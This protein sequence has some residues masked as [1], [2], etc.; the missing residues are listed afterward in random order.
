MAASEEQQWCAD[1]CKVVVAQL[2]EGDF[3]D[4]LGHQA[5]CAVDKVVEIGHDLG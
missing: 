5:E 2:D 1:L 3:E 4:A